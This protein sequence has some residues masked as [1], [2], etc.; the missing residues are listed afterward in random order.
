M[1][2][3]AILLAISSLTFSSPLLKADSLNP[4]GTAASFAVLGASTVTNT[5]SSVISGNLGVAP[6]TSI[7]GF[8]PGV[9]I[10]GTQHLN[11]GEAILAQAQSLNGYDT[12]AKLPYTQDL[13][14]QNLG[15][16]ILF[17]GIYHY[18]SSALLTGNLTID[19]QGADNTDAIFQ[20]GSTLTSDTASQVNIINAG[21][22]NN[23]F[24][25]VGSSATLGTTT[26]FEGTIVA[27]QSITL[28]TGASIHCGS[29]LALN[30]AVTLDTNTITACPVTSSDSSTPGVSAVP[31]P[32][33]F[34]LMA[35]GLLGIAGVLRR[36]L[37][38]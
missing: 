14:G 26:A 18:S 24:W 11:D 37:N 36:R 21:L 6:G 32:G 34:N 16:L 19:F 22:N 7:T 9:V 23:I 3:I 33:T 28:N 17:S 4:F 15:G 35:T 5:G 10:N 29:A 12:L 8:P 20:I 25:Q 38:R 13:T 2:R 1:N 30:G 31:E 27:D